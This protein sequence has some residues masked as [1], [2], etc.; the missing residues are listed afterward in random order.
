MEFNA[1]LGH[2][3]SSV[4]LSSAPPQASLQERWRKTHKESGGHRGPGRAL[5]EGTRSESELGHT[6]LEGS[7]I[8][9]GMSLMGQKMCPQC[10]LGLLPHRPP[11]FNKVPFQPRDMEATGPRMGSEGRSLAG[12]H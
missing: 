5:T 7:A 9:A 2:N 4:T 10:E 6:G 1:V 11:N 12:E 8:Q 3:K